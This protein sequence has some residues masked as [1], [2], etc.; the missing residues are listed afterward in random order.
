MVREGRKGEVVEWSGR[1]WTRDVESE[2][3]E[4]KRAECVDIEREGVE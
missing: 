4:G 1:L 2:D 3:M